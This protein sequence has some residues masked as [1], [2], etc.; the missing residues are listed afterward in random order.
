MENISIYSDIIYSEDVTN[1]IAELSNHHER[2]D[3]EDHE[4][5]EL[6]KLE[7]EAKMYNED[8]DYGESL[9]R[10]SYFKEYAMQLADEISGDGKSEN[11][12]FNCID[13]EMAAR[14]LKYDYSALDYDGITYWIRNT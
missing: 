6:L 7:A 8:W 14:E 13:W 2:N 12:P 11:W 9:I 4:L 10:D 5:D 1:R 3:A